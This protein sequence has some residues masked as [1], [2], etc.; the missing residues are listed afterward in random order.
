MH[1]DRGC[2]VVLFTDKRLGTYRYKDRRRIY[3]AIGDDDGA[4]RS[5]AGFI[6]GSNDVAVVDTFTAAAPGFI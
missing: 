3:V 6:A 2:L 4:A 1:F 5:N